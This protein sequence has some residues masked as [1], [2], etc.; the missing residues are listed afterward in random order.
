MEIDKAESKVRVRSSKE[1]REW[2]ESYDQLLITTG[3]NPIRPAVPGADAVGIY[4]LSS[5]EDG[6]AIR[7]VVDSGDIKQAVIVG[8][9]Y[10]GI[11]MAEALLNRGIDVSLVEKEPQVMNTLDSDM[12]AVVNEAL[13]EAG[14]K[15]Y[16]DEPLTGFD[17]ERGK[18]VEVITDKNTIPAD[19]VILGIGVRPNSHI[20]EKS[21]I[22]VG[23]RKAIK[24]N[25][26]MQTEVAGI[27]AAGDCAVSFHLVS[28]KP[29]F[30]ALGTVANKHGRVA[31]IN[32][33]GGEAIFQGV[34]GTAITKFNKLEIARTG[35]Q[36]RE[37][38]MMG[39][40]YASAK[41]TGKTKPEYYPGAKRITVKIHAEKDSGRV[42]GGQIVGYE[43]SGKRIDVIATAL[44]QGLTIAEMINLDLAYA[45][46]FSP[47]WDPV[48]I[49]ARKAESKL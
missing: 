27:W 21:G 42:L 26:L 12:G 2:W 29:T 24:V 39:I 18:V 48:L 20:A 22:P 3:A 11:E 32:I 6:L 44:H 47:V 41:I 10:I 5:F 40:E 34:V 38:D 14:V 33:A 30:I 45:P 37:L 25:S 35:L 36:E 8:G 9:G 4:G 49:A 1:S 16:L 28:R 46:P 19:M 7:R 15:L 43:S 31:G 17:V 13:A 23:E